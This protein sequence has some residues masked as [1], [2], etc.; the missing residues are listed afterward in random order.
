MP[1]DFEKLV[2]NSFPL[3]GVNCIEASA[4]TGKTY[5]IAALYIR[6]I[7]G[8]GEEGTRNPQP[9][10]KILVVT[11][12]DAATSELRDRIRSKIVEARKAFKDMQ[13]D[14]PIIAE[15]ISDLAHKREDCIDMLVQAERQINET[16]IHTIHG[17][18]QRILK[19]SAFETGTPFESEF[20]TDDQEIFNNVVADYWRKVFYKLDK[21]LAGVI[22]S[23]WKTPSDMINTVKAMITSNVKVLSPHN[24]T[25]DSVA[26]I[27]SLH[28]TYIKTINTLKHSVDNQINDAVIEIRNSGISKSAFQDRYL[29]KWLEKINAWVKSE[30]HDYSHPPELEKFTYTF[31]EEKTKN[32]ILANHALID[33]ISDFVSNKPSIHS[34]IIADAIAKCHSALEK[35]KAKKQVI[36]F[37]DLLINLNDALCSEDGGDLLAQTIRESFPVAM[38]DE[39]QDTDSIQYSIFKKIYHNA[40]IDECNQNYCLTTIGDPK[41][42]IYSFRGADIYTYIDTKNDAQQH[43]TLDTNWRSTENMIDAV[44][45]LFSI[46]PQAFLIKGI[47]YSPVSAP[48]RNN[49]TRLI[50]DGSPASALNVIIDNADKVVSK[51]QYTE[52]MANLTAKQIST[53]IHSNDSYIADESGNNTRV[54]PQDI[55]ILV[56]TANEAEIIKDSLSKNGIDSVFLSAKT[57][58]YSTHEAKDIL[59]IITA[60]A[61][62]T[63]RNI[64]S[65]LATTL[66]DMSS[67]D[68]VEIDEREVTIEEAIDEFVTYKKIWVRHGVQAAIS[69][70]LEIRNIVEHIMSKEQAER[71]IANILHI[72]SALQSQQVQSHQQLIRF[73]NDKIEKP[74][75]NSED[76]QL[77]LESD[78]DLVQIIT[79]HKSKGLEYKVV[80]IPFVLTNRDITEAVFHDVDNIPTFSPTPTKE[81]DKQA[82]IEKMAEDVRLLY[83]AVTRSVYSCY[84]GIAPLMDGNKRSS[85]TINKT[86]IGWLLNKSEYVSPNDLPSMMQDFAN[87][88]PDNINLIY[89]NQVKSMCKQPID[90]VEPECTANQCSTK[91]INLKNQ[92]VTSYSALVSQ[93]GGESTI[94]LAPTDRDLEVVIE[95]EEQTDVELSIFNF[96][97]GAKAGTFLHSIFEEINYNTRVDS[98]KTTSKIQELIAMNGET[99]RDSDSELIKK[100]SDWI[101]P[102]KTMVSSVLE[103]NLM[104]GFSN[105]QIRLCDIDMEHILPEMEFMFP[106]EDL[107]AISLSKLI[108]K[109]DSLSENLPDL[110]FSDISGMI[111]GFID[112]TFKANGKYYVLDWKSNHLGDDSSVY[113]IE[114]IKESMRDH[115]YDLQYQI[116]SLALHKFL[117]TRINDYNYETHFGGAFYVYL[118]GVDSDVNGIF[119]TKPS[120]EFLQELDECFHK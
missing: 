53:L 62:P 15:I 49:N 41:Q 40:C 89:A 34:Y 43:F 39:S 52:T 32:G 118:R 42:A 37:D 48:I 30:T 38:I 4:G 103:R 10:D 16:A 13:S 59:R 96:E 97:K 9:A 100:W 31:L 86:A 19:Q 81:Q 51:K 98:D 77:Q 14:D 111:K 11:F 22:H 69:K 50:V 29:S 58:V 107:N 119:Y 28:S 18:C 78:R 3:I 65:A 45:T 56:R 108:A 17:F 79:I 120:Y 114:S 102:I 2:P 117:S 88:N 116:Y 46:N 84:L 92:F 75:S 87:N 47:Q 82:R 67:D 63:Q 91:H 106:I 6:L 101:E 72:A 85:T 109:H 33:E 36:S 21:N 112:L 80:F 23:K 8:H 26:S 66:I 5:T 68:L 20:I 115:R 93:H 54:K 94:A 64:K 61:S 74:Q 70:L 55:A 90:T 95:D 7:L 1:Q 35:E 27:N 25:E 105:E 44:N 12:T 99:R 76:E 71:K 83:V 57:S 73:L 60:M 24:I 113:T 110:E 104:E